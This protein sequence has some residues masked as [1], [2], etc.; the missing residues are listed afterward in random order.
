MFKLFKKEEVGQALGLD[1]GTSSIKVVQLRREKDKIILDTYGEIA[2]GP[3]AGMLAGQ[4]VHLGEEKT[5]E[6]INDVFKEARFTE[7]EVEEIN[8]SLYMAIQ[9]AML[10]D[11]PQRQAFLNGYEQYIQQK[12]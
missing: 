6:A 10:S 8:W 1:I 12:L 2:L 3:Y 9:L 7:E 4:A 5:I 11:C